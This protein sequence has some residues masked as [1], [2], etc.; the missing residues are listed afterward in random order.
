MTMRRAASPSSQVLRLSWRK[1]LRKFWVE[2][3]TPRAQ[4]VLTHRNVYILPTRAGLVFALTLMVLLIASIN[5]QL[6]LGHLL[7]F[8]LAGSAIV[9]MH[10]THNTLRGLNLHL[11]EQGAVHAASPTELQLLIDVPAGSTRRGIGVCLDRPGDADEWAW[12]DGPA[13]SQVSVTLRYTP[14]QRGWNTLPAVVIHTRYPFGLFRAWSVWRPAQQVLA[15]PRVETPTAPWPVHPRTDPASPRSVNQHSED[16]EGV[17]PYRRGDAWHDIV[18]KKSTHGPLIS[19]DHA[20]AVTTKHILDW[21]DTAGLGTEARLSRLCAWVLAADQLGWDYGLVLPGL[22]IV[23][24]RGAPHRTRLLKALAL[25][26]QIQPG[27]ASGAGAPRRAAA[28][29]TM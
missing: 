23:P 26:P 14:A 19:R 5:Y 29:A 1:R 13:G 15:Y 11:G 7:T 25:W 6:N 4:L 12:L 10:M 28:V 17:R 20:R 9:S 24:T 18:W 16:A 8:L 3:H 27:D 22:S 2:R 21:D